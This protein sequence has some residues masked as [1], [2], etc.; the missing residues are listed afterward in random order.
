MNYEDIKYLIL[1][2]KFDTEDEAE[3]A[4]ER[5]KD[6]IVPETIDATFSIA[7]PLVRVSLLREHMLTPVKLDPVTILING[8]TNGEKTTTVI[9]FLIINEKLRYNEE[10]SELANKPTLHKK[11]GGTVAGDGEKQF[12]KGFET[13]EQAAEFAMNISTLMK[14]NAL[15]VKIRQDERIVYLGLSEKTLAAA[16]A[17]PDIGDTLGEVRELK[18]RRVFYTENKARGK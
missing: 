6:T 5:I 7:G 12:F 15:D 9:D 1:E 17:R 13:E 10:K 4:L 2:K 18:N 16:L 3:T 11:R 14:E 8:L